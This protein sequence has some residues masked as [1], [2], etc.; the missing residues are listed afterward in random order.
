MAAKNSVGE[1]FAGFVMFV[2]VIVGIIFYA[3]SNH[4]WD[5]H[6]FFI[7]V[8]FW[9]GPSEKEIR[10]KLGESGWTNI[11]DIDRRPAVESGGDHKTRK[12][13]QLYPARIKTNVPNSNPASVTLDV[14]FYRD[15]FGELRWYVD[16]HE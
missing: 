11:E 16:E 14:Y 2:A 7:T 10:A 3:G 15:D 13:T 1:S 8:P 4:G 12:G 6:S 9:S 5:R